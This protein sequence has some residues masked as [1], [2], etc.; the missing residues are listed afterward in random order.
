MIDPAAPPPLSGPAPRGAESI[1]APRIGR[2]PPTAELF[3]ERRP[4]DAR[5]SA[6]RQGQPQARVVRGGGALALARRAPP[7]ATARQPALPAVGLALRVGFERV[8][9]GPSLH[10]RVPLLTAAPTEPVARAARLAPP[11]AVGSALRID[12]PA[13]SGP[14][15]GAV[16][17]RVG[18]SPKELLP[19]LHPTASTTAAAA[20]GRP[21]RQAPRQ[22][23]QAT[24][25]AAAPEV[26][27]RAPPQAVGFALRVGIERTGG[28]R[29][30]GETEPH[31]LAAVHWVRL[32]NAPTEPVARAARLA[33][34]ADE[35]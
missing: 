34:P 32:V 21:R 7:R 12:P 24:G 14:A 1:I 6:A 4:T 18:R 20:P 5:T 25:T 8:R 11:A 16:V 31:S 26:A 30:G 15:D 9:R 13:L 28:V 22:A 29:R 23:P 33:P 10:D 35:G 27:R 3:G 2:F 17:P 19:E